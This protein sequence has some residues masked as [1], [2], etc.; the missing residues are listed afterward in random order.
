MAERGELRVV[1]QAPSLDDLP[2]VLTV[3]E[4]ARVLRISRGAAYELA[5]QWRES[6]GRHGLPV[7][8]LG[9][10][11]RVPRHALRRFLDIGLDAQAS[12]Q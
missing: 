7:V 12:G 9:R 6:G 10:S 2:E 1:R 11:L 3:E 8:T 4:A 5:R